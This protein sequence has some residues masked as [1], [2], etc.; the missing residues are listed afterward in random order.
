MPSAKSSNDAPESLR[1][2]RR[3]RTLL[4]GVLALLGGA[5]ALFVGCG[6]VIT[7]PANVHDPVRVYIADY[8][9]HSSLVLPTPEGE[10]VEY[11][12]G[13]WNWFALNKDGWWRTPG[14][15]LIP[16][17]GALGRSTWPVFV[18]ASDA[19]RHMRVVTVIEVSVDRERA[20]ALE[21]RLRERFDAHADTAR[22]N[23]RYGLEFVHDD[24]SYWLFNHCNTAV[25]AWLRELGCEVRGATLLADFRLRAPE[26]EGAAPG[27]HTL[28]TE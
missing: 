21:R 16:S 11:A 13:E 23:P 10:A 3:R 26:P 4:I 8:G 17:R 6:A 2:T 20:A 27:D 9:R 24:D 19:Q 15:V 22:N 25:A 1:R 14:V 28:G 7:P 18:D 5:S 12:Y